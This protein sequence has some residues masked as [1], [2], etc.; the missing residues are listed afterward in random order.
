MKMENGRAAFCFLIGSVIL[1]LVWLV[2][3]DGLAL[4]SKNLCADGRTNTMPVQWDQVS[5]KIIAHL[6]PEKLERGEVISEV[7][8]IDSRT[9]T[10]Q[11]VGLIKADPE[12]C[13]KVVRSY[14]QYAQIM[15]CTVE[16]RIIRS[17]KLEGDY[18]GAEAVDFWTRVSVLGFDT[19]YLLRIAHLSDPDSRRFR[20]F[21]T[22]VNN[23]SEVAG[24]CDSGKAPCE[25]DL[26]LNLG[27][28]QFEPYTGNPNYT[29]HTYTV[30]LEGK[31]WLQQSAFRLGGWKTMEEVTQRIRKALKVKE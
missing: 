19:R 24:V 5:R 11:C 29:L 8:K 12:A 31:N 2:P 25:N 7:K 1:A 27:S 20:C 6:N 21:W 10:A 30:T 9:V 18:A 14:S 23:P 13:F 16:N 15:P 4:P 26:A 17:F 28:H 3:V 22:L